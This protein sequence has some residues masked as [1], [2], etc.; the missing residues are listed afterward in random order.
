M[1]EGF[2]LTTDMIDKE[3]E[4]FRGIINGKQSELDIILEESRVLTERIEIFKR[5]EKVVKE[6]LLKRVVEKNIEMLADERFKKL[7]TINKLESTI[8]QFSQLINYLEGLKDD[9]LN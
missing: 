6:D 3:I 5:L 7:P 2:T 4:N 1:M 8:N 9:S